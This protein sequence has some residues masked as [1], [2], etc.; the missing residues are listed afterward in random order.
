M[1]AE[2]VK[3]LKDL[4]DVLER[5][6]QSPDRDRLLDEVRSRAV[7][8]DT[9]VAPRAM[10]P[11]QEPA[12]APVAPMPKPRRLSRVSLAAQPQRARAM[13]PALPPSAAS[14]STDREHVFW[15]AERL[16]LE[17]SP[18]FPSSH[19]AP[20]QGGRAVRPWTLG[21]RG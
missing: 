2:R 11:I 1:A 16:S 6:P 19:H 7:D 9:G 5:L 4:T 17:E 10:L 13:E 12:H 21:L 14:P 15:A 8:L 20:A 18:E 3:R